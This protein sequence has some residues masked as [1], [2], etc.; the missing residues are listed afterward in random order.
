MNEIA[1]NSK[2]SS[3]KKLFNK[4]YSI[5]NESDMNQDLDSVLESTPPS[6][7]KEIPIAFK[8]YS[9]NAFSRA[10]FHEEEQ[11]KFK[12][13][14]NPSEKKQE[15]LSSRR[16]ISKKT[17]CSQSHSNFNLKRKSYDKSVEELQ[18]KA[19]NPQKQGDFIDYFS[20]HHQSENFERYRNLR[21]KALTGNF[22]ISDFFSH[23]LQLEEK[24]RFENNLKIFNNSIQKE[25]RPAYLDTP[26]NIFAPQKKKN[27]R[28]RNKFKNNDQENTSDKLFLKATGGNNFKLNSPM[29]K[30]SVLGKEGSLMN[31]SKAVDSG[32]ECKKV[33]FTPREATKPNIQ[34]FYPQN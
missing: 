4:N 14:N 27:A 9:K 29:G 19:P 26:K 15:I 3:P 10:K 1:K 16:E 13:A 33:S 34:K 22:K 2:G 20:K 6:N 25:E 32:L 18:E 28:D 12:P 31:F 7:K 21:N 24:E 17:E 11:I 8:Q 30:F 5:T 23:T